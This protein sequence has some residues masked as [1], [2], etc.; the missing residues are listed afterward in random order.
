MGGHRGRWDTLENGHSYPINRFDALLRDLIT[1]G[2]V[3]Q[4]ETK[5]GP[6]W[7]LVDAAQRR[8]GELMWPGHPLVAE[9]VIY[10][11]HRCAD[12]HLRAPTRLHEGSYLCDA[13]WAMRSEAAATLPSP[14]APPPPRRRFRRS[15]ERP[16]G[17]DV[18]AG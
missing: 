2:L 11:D 5:D 4:E 13:C 8:L 9:A 15:R 18:V 3:D 6:S 10:L 7:R 1:W 16:A 14:E 12:C 17:Q